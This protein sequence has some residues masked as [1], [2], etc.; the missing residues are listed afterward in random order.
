VLTP[1]MRTRTVL[2]APGSRA[3]GSVVFG[4]LLL[5]TRS[6]NVERPSGLLKNKIGRDHERSSQR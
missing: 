1:F 6:G 4:D 5:S 2:N 3:R